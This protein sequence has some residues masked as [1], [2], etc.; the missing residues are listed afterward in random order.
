MVTVDSM[1][2]VAGGYTAYKFSIYLADGANAGSLSNTISGGVC[3]GGG[4]IHSVFSPWTF[5]ANN[6][7]PCASGA[8]SVLQTQIKA[9]P[10]AQSGAFGLLPSMALLFASAML[11]Y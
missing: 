2:S 4:S 6:Q 11:Q 5:R 9:N 3:S 10:Q 7:G 8:L 1:N